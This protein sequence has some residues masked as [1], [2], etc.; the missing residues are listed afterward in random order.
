MLNTVVPRTKTRYLSRGPCQQEHPLIVNPQRQG[1]STAAEVL[2]LG[3]PRA[4]MGHEQ[5][6]GAICR[7]CAWQLLLRQLIH[8][9]FLS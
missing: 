6:L 5:F 2:A 8:L 4:A 7:A 3:P 9:H 1:S